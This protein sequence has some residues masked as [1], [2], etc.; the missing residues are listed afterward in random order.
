MN[1][2]KRGF[3]K[4]FRYICLVSSIVLGLITIVATGGGGGSDGGV[5]PPPPP[6]QEESKWDE[7]IWDQDKWA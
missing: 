4:S 2:K 3:F 5:T 6:P 7:M 1:K